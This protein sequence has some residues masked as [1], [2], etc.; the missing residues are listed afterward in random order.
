MGI[1]MTLHLKPG[2]ILV[3]IDM[4]NA[5]ITT[6]RRAAI[7]ERHR[8]HMTMRRAVPYWK[9]KLGPRASIWAGDT[10]MW[11]DEGLQQGSPTSGPAFAITIHPFVREADRRLEAAGGCVRFGMDDG[12]FVGPREVM[13]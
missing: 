10:T 7:L 6:M 8:G 11:G 9:A 13:F 1:K 2:H 4:R 3:S 12:H 5:Y